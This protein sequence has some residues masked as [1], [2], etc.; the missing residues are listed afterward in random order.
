MLRPIKLTTEKKKMTKTVDELY[1]YCTLK[2]IRSP[3]KPAF[4][5][6][7][8]SIL[9]EMKKHKKYRLNLLNKIRQNS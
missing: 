7:K 8:L 5:V 4:S 2:T 3:N 6:A 1:N 9:S